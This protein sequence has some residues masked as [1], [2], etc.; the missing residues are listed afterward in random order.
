MIVPPDFPHRTLGFSFSLMYKAALLI[1]SGWQWV[2]G[3]T[4]PE[5][6]EPQSDVLLAWWYLVPVL[7]TNS[8][9]AGEE[10][11]RGD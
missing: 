1:A 10:L 6:S 9:R 8:A 11:A 5:P 2:S 4:H 7:G 3:G